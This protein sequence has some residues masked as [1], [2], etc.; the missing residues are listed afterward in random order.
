MT[1]SEGMMDMS[2]S[3]QIFTWMGARQLSVSLNFLLNQTGNEKIVETICIL[4]WCAPNTSK[5]LQL[6]LE[7]NYFLLCYILFLQIHLKAILNQ[8][9]FIFFFCSY[10][11]R[12]VLQP[13]SS[14]ETYA[15]QVLISS[16][17]FIPFCIIN[18]FFQ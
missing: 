11:S 7:K 12:S 16:N 17:F 6:Q 13:T 18:N 9:S 15:I 8:G 14:K 5:H 2:F 1:Y 4:L 10:C 3:R